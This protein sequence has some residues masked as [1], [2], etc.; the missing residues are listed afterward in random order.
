M[1]KCSLQGRR[2]EGHPSQGCVQVL[3]MLGFSLSLPRAFPSPSLCYYT[4]V[5]LHSDDGSNLNKFILCFLVIGKQ[6][7]E[8]YPSFSEVFLVFV[9]GVLGREWSR[10][11]TVIQ[12]KTSFCTTIAYDKQQCTNAFQLHCS[13]L[14]GEEVWGGNVVAHHPWLCLPFVA[15]LTCYWFVMCVHIKRH[16]CQRSQCMHVGRYT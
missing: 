3:G 1:L 11:S 6:G 4:L 14:C 8:L 13:L 16:M 12:I 5:D 9:W 15:R 2:E 10:P 7:L